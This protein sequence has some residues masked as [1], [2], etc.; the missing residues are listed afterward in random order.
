MVFSSAQNPQ[1]DDLS[2]SVLGNSFPALPLS[3]ISGFKGVPWWGLSLDTARLCIFPSS[4]LPT[5]KEPSPGHQVNGGKIGDSVLSSLWWTVSQIID[6]LHQL[7]EVNNIT[8][9][10]RNGEIEAHRGYVDCNQPGSEPRSPG[11]QILLSVYSVFLRLFF[12]TVSY[13]FLKKSDDLVYVCT[14]STHVHIQTHTC[15]CKTSPEAIVAFIVY[16]ALFYSLFFLKNAGQAIAGF[17]SFFKA[18]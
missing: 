4:V 14:Y 18:E 9:R 8:A 7:Q 11:F 16:D 13:S 12:P 1:L 3:D 5:D 6:P 17:H 2:P 10:F 15:R